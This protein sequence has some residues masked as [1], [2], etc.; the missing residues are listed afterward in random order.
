M[1]TF[2]FKLRRIYNDTVHFCFATAVEYEN[3]DIEANVED[4][5][6]NIVGKGNF[7]PGMDVYYKRGDGHNKTTRH[8][9]TVEVNGT[10]LHKIQL[11]VGTLT[12]VPAYHLQLLE[13]SD[14][15]NIP[16]DV[17]TYCKEVEAGLT[18]EDIAA[19]AIPQ[20]PS[21]LQKESVY[22]HNRLYQ[23]PNHQLIQ[24]PRED[25]I[26]HRLAVLKDKPSICATCHFG[27]AHK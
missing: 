15:T 4:S 24:V 17:E 2:Y 22:W 19:I 26:L 20:P 1:S 6:E 12:N 3:D 13:Q 27:W 8:I 5:G 25:V 11:P 23:M 18:T 14:L 21:P 9:N 7:K 16:I 10:K